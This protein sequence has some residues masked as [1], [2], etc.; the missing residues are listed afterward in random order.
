MTDNVTTGT[1]TGPA[2]EDIRRRIDAVDT[3]ILKALAQRFDLVQHVKALKQAQKQSPGSPLRPA[4]EMEILHRLTSMAAELNLNPALVVRLWPMI[5][6]DATQSQS[7]VTIHVGRKLHQSIAQR[8]RI[9]DYYGAMPV[10]EC[11]DEA[12][13]LYQVQ[14]NSGDICIV[15]TDSAWA[16]HLAAGQAGDAQVIAALP[17][18]RGV[19]QA[20]PRLLVIGVSPA[21]PTGDD[22]TLVISKGALPRAFSVTPLWHCKSGDYRVSALPGFLSVQ[23]QPFIS[24]IRSNPPLGLKLVGRYPSALELS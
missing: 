2:L 17:V 3:A 6:A 5:I 11:K 22:E 7:P 19:D 13:A 16:E 12:Q 23:E 14:A 4:R 8:M 20:M 15:E 9:R 1:T 18:L 10:E 24:L 21:E